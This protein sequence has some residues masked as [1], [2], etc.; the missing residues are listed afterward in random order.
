[1]PIDNSLKILAR[2]ILAQLP[3]DRGEAELVLRYVGGL[4]EASEGVFHE[5]RPDFL[6]LVRSGGSPAA[7][8]A[9]STST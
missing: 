6:T 1:M 9:R 8:K 7:S 5:R 2:Q 3:T 4:V